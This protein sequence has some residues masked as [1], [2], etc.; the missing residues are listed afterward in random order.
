ME[1][2]KLIDELLCIEAFAESLLKKCYS[3][4][5][6]LMPEGFHPQASSKKKSQ[7]KI[8]QVIANRNKSINRKSSNLKHLLVF[9]FFFGSV[10]AQTFSIPSIDSLYSSVD[11]YFEDLTKSQIEEFKTSSKHRWLNYLPSP[12]YSPFTGGFSFSLNISGP[13][14]EI[15]IK[16]LSRQKIL[17][18]QRLNQIQC[19][20]LKNEVFTDFKALE[21][22]VFEFHSKDTLVYLK[23]EAFNLAKVQY[24]RNELTPTEFLARQYEIKSLTIQ[25]IE[26]ANNIYK[27][28]L[29]L[30]L[31]SKNPMHIN[32]PA[33]IF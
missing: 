32:A 16:N 11:N 26:E 10:S 14:Q 18:I 2:Q 7:T 12:G 25:R 3:V 29:L 33:S 15:K 8:D 28:I 31:K 21:I 22:A 30:L 23:H 24:S 4:R 9:L 6:T 20:A 17:S 13:L 19:N 5:Q 1:H 27:S